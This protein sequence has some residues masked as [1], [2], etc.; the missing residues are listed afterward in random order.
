M[1]KQGTTTLRWKDYAGYFYLE[2]TSE[3]L[4][5]SLAASGIQYYRCDTETGTYFYKLPVAWLRLRTA[6]GLLKLGWYPDKRKQ[7]EAALYEER[8]KLELIK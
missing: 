5:E 7:K 4:A 2:T 6:H 1:R 8:P 3:K